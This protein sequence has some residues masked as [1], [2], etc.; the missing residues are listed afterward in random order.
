MKCTFERQIQAPPQKVWRILTDVAEMPDRFPQFRGWTITR[1][2]RNSDLVAL[3]HRRLN[4]TGKP[5]YVVRLTVLDYGHAIEAEYLE[6]DLA[7]MGHTVVYSLEPEDD[8]TL[9][10]TVLDAEGLIG[11]AYM[12]FVIRQYLNRLKEV[13]EAE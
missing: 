3:S 12:F 7:P 8:G 1:D 4:K 11:F 5:E 13:A 9:L 2:P 10:T 6:A